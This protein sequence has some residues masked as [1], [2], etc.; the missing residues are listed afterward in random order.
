[1][2]EN[3]KDNLKRIWSVSFVIEKF[4]DIYKDKYIQYQSLIHY[5]IKK[6]LQILRDDIIQNKEIKLNINDFLSYID[7]KLNLHINGSIKKII[8]ATGI[9]INTNIG[10][11]P[12]SIKSL[13][14]NKD[15]SCGYFN[16][17]FD[18]ETSKRG[19]RQKHLENLLTILTNA[20]S[21]FIVNNNAA[22]LFL[23]CNTFAKNKKVIASRGEL[24]E[25]GDSFRLTDIIESSQAI[26]KEV[27]TTNKTYVHDYENNID[28]ETAILLKSHTSNFKIIGF[29]Q[30]VTSKQLSD[31][32]K[33]KGLI[34]FED[35]G[36]GYLFDLNISQL[37]DEP[38]AK[39]KIEEG[40]DIVCFSGDKLLGSAQAG[41]IIGKKNL[42][43]KIKINPIARTMRIDKN[44]LIIL[45]DTLKTYLMEK[46]LIVDNIPVLKMI[47]LSYEEIYKRILIIKENIEKLPLIINIKDDYSKIG[48]GSSPEDLILTPVLEIKSANLSSNE[49]YL[50][51]KKINPSILTT[52]KNDFVILNLRTVFI[53][54]DQIIIDSLNSIF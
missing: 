44:S 14:A 8:N 24:V 48:G 12:I 47:N 3:L 18:L 17:E 2:H 5:L 31:L 30:D 13:E 38:N 7:S 46:K 23:V 41:I 10:R 20:E 26:L 49:L 39:A 28:D 25:I 19:S 53:E 22:A 35:I 4:K 33:R 1:M 34:S 29:T 37:K 36:S 54:Q 27:G 11:A 51:L 6:E 52:I 9:I 15:I 16:L 45:G 32:S 40:I 42:I 50:K 21:A 43:D